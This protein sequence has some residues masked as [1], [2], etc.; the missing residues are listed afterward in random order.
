MFKLIG[1]LAVAAGLAW[2]TAQAAP[3]NVLWWDTTPT[4]GGQAPDALRQAMS[5]YLT[6]FGGGGVFSSTYVSAESQPGTL[7]A[8]LASTAYDVIVFDS[9]PSGTGTS[10][11][12]ADFS[13]IGSFYDAGNKNIMLDGTLYIRSISYSPATVFPG[14]NGALG[15]LLANQVMQLAT[16]GGGML[17]GTDHDCCQGEANNILKAA[18]PGM[19]GF[20]G[21][22][23]PTTVG[24]FFG[25][26]L[27]NG[28]AVAIA[29]ADVFNNWAGVPSEAVAAT[30]TFVDK[31]GASVTF[32]SQVDVADAGGGGL[33]A[34]Q[35]YT[36]I[37]TSWAPGSGSTGVVD[38]NPGG[39]GGGGT[40][41]PE[42]SPLALLGLAIAGLALTRRRAG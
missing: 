37:S 5:D 3:V 16:R 22:T 9:T 41:V 33:V 13:A 10:L 26:D 31:N 35:L 7:A 18:V 17:I 6:N 40:A 25:S 32:Y 15:G 14:A 19:T 34:G 27:L 11:N 2:G 1:K 36:Y 39:S 4:Y 42:P 30:G 8:R 29:A 23:Y 12:A 20:S 38:P 21:V 28:G 24:S